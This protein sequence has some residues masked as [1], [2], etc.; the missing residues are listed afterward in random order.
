M[1][2]GGPSGKQGE[3][4]RETSQRTA[5]KKPPQQCF[6]KVLGLLG[7]AAGLGVTNLISQ[8]LGTASRLPQGRGH[9][10]S[11]FLGD[12]R[13]PVGQGLLPQSSG[14]GLGTGDCWLNDQCLG[15]LSVL[16]PH[17]AFWTLV[18]VIK[19]VQDRA[20]LAASLLASLLA[21]SSLISVPSLMTILA[22]RGLMKSRGKIRKPV[23]YK[24]NNRR[25]SQG[26]ELCADI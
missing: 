7:F 15:Q 2:Q 26:Q 19:E 25:A 23:T 3:P 9:P 1:S 8:C 24:Y 5:G 12:H 18:T 4:G 16:L 22:Q 14:T 11:C 21:K 6:V 17:W 20:R 10:C 13:F